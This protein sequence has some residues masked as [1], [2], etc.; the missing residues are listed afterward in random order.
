MHFNST[1]FIKSQPH[2]LGLLVIKL[3]AGSSLM[4]TALTLPRDLTKSPPPGR[5]LGPTANP[6]HEP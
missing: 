6:H 2:F 3:L 4:Q 5:I 1:Y